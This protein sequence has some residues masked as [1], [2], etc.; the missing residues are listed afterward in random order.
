MYVPHRYRVDDERALDE[1]VRAHGFALLLTAAGGVPT[2]SHVPVELVRTADGARLLEGHLARANPQWRTFGGGARALAVFLGPHAYVS[3]SWYDHENVP[4]WNYQAVHLSGPIEPVHDP[5]ELLDMVRRLAR[6]Y[7]P[8]GT[9]DG[10]DVDRLTP[11]FRA[12]ELR[13]IVGFRVRVERVEAAFKLSQNRDA[14]NRARVVERLRARGDAGS[15]A[16]AEAMARGV[17]A[18]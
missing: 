11:R 16:V 18:S 13:G 10:F 5:A 9:P 7:E 1:F 4:T 17:G 15:A 2:G 8:A 12:A 6:H 14:A 3:S